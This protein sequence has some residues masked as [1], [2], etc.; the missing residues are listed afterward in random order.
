MAGEGIS[1]LTEH[2]DNVA[3]ALLGG[4]VMVKSIKEENIPLPVPKDLFVLLLIQIEVKTYIQGIL[5]REV[6]LNLMT[7]QVANFMLWY[8]H[9]IL[10]L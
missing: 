9:F 4:L 8:M 5:P 6:E 3:P 2:P 7:K 1:S 10:K